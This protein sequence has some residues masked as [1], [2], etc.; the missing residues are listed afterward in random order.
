MRT[1]LL[2][3]LVLAAV[4]LP[5][6]SV[7]TANASPAQV[8]ERPAPARGSGW[9]FAILGDNRDDP[10]SVFPVIVQAIHADGN[11][12]FVLHL[13]DMVRSGDSRSSKTF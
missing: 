3:G 1:S 8:P 5:A 13:G 6:C 12:V 11:L 7:R 4:S 2:A 10:D 9:S